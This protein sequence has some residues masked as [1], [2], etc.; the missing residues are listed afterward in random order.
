MCRLVE[1]AE[2]ILHL[3]T[4]GSAILA[5]ERITGTEKKLILRLLAQVGADCEGMLSDLVG[6]AVQDVQADEVWS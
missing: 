1:K 4:E 3:L 6:V 5:I 2:L